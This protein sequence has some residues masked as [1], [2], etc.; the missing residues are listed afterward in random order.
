[1]P[2]PS[3]WHQQFETFVETWKRNPQAREYL[4]DAPFGHFVLTDYASSWA[5]FLEWLSGLK[6]TWCFRGQREASWLLHTSLDLAVRVNTATGYFH[7]NREE[8]GRDLL[9]RFQQQAREFLRYVPNEDDLGS[10]FM[11]MQHH[12]VPT[13]LLDWTLSPYVALYFAVE[14]EARGGE[15]ELPAGNERMSALWAIDLGWLESEG[16]RVLVRHDSNLGISGAP[17][18]EMP[19]DRRARAD[20]INRRL[21]PGAAPAIV[22]IDPLVA[23]ERMVAQQGVALCKLVH[24]ASFNQMLMSMMLHN[25]PKDPV[26][27][28]LEMANE[29]RIDILKRLRAMNIHRATLFPGIDGFGKFLRMEAEV[30]AFEARE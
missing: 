4:G 15:G 24:E 29:L 22:R 28:K 13:R 20:W 3:D 2:E 27:R 21:G 25:P 12:G 19:D 9:Y 11:L 7:L 8:V 6:G 23:S 10:W 26:I 17:D 30:K 18:S 5:A 14:E 16:R 1:M